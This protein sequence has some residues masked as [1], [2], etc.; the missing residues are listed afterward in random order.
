MRLRRT[1]AYNALIELVDS[2][3]DVLASAQC[4]GRKAIVSARKLQTLEERLEMFVDACCDPEQLDAG[5]N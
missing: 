4:G 1:R 2:I 3:Y 5:R